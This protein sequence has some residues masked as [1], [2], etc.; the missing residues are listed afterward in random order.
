MKDLTMKLFNICQENLYEDSFNFE[1][2]GLDFL[3]GKDM[4]VWLIECNTNP[5]LEVHCSLQSRLV[6]SLI[7]NLLNIVVDPLF[8][9]P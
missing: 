6:P 5:S 8:P 2:F 3:V 1:L 9:C 4:K 7:E